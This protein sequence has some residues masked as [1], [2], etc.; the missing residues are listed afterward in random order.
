MSI[1]LK[2]RCPTS[3]HEEFERKAGQTWTTHYC[4]GCGHGVVHKYVAEAIDDFGLQDNTVFVSPV[5]CAVFA[6]Y[7]FDVGN[8]QVAHGRA[9]A[10]ATALKRANPD[11]LVIGYQGDGDL[12][13]IGGNEILHAANRGEN[14]TIFF[15]NNA[16]YG[17]TGGQMAPTTLMDMKT[18]TTPTGR[19]AEND[20]F[21]IRVCELLSTLDAPYYLERVAVGD[22]KHNNKARK[23]VHKA[24]ENQVNNKGF[25]LVEIL[26]PC[27]TSW[28]MSP[29][30][31][32]HYNLEEMTKTFPLGVYRD[33]HELELG[34]PRRRREVAQR[35]IPA[36]IG[37]EVEQSDVDLPDHTTSIDEAR[38]KVSGFG[39]QGVLLLGQMLSQAGMLARRQVSWMPSYG[40]E[41][42]GGTANCSVTLSMQEIGS[43]VIQN[44]SV[45][46][47]MNQPSIERFARDVA[48]GGAIL[49]N[50]SMVDQPPE[51]DDVEVV[52]VA[53][54]E[55]ADRLGDPTVANMV[56]LG[57]LLEIGC[58]VSH[59]AVL[60]A[61]PVVCKS[62]PQLIELNKKAIQEGISAVQAVKLS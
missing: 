41:M 59:E 43:P 5:G 23:A 54:N 16:I 53:A 47:A 30:D 42:R 61:L 7:Y 58:A 34:H 62:R 22:P 11:S 2:H 50:S 57:A 45:L 51:R 6:Y 20:G 49:Y 24:I 9:P 12:A 18:T 52:P 33:G 37:A 56:V 15:I 14:V 10:A 36:I 21:P 39:G 3:I 35:D 27:P 1:E 17:M 46:V 55:I 26:S 29:V 25:S 19:H 31:A 44:P 32:A 4:P 60:A 48:P 13:A 8:I 38:Y 28:K 40:P